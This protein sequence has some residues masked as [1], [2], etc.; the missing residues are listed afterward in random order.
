MAD[1][2]Y[3]EIEF[4]R[5]IQ[6]SVDAKAAVAS[7]PSPR[8]WPISGDGVTEFNPDGHP[9]SLKRPPKRWVDPELHDET[10]E[11]LS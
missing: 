1:S 5:T 8:V 4:T 11:E 6:E 2:T 7:E 3:W 9:L 10:T